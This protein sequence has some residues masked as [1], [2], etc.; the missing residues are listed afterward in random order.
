M[1]GSRLRHHVRAASLHSFHLKVIQSDKI[2]DDGEERGEV[3]A[4]FYNGAFS[5]YDKS[6][7]Q[8]SECLDTL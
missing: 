1:S 4:S 6:F 2:F 3:Y 5:L 7:L 8:R